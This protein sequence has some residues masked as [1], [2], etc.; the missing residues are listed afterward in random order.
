[1]KAHSS[2][3]IYSIKQT[4]WP[5][6]R[7]SISALSLQQDE[8]ELLLLPVHP[9]L[10]MALSD[11]LVLSPEKS[12]LGISMVIVLR[13]PLWFPASI[14]GKNKISVNCSILEDIENFPVGRIEPN[15]DSGL[16]PGIFSSPVGKETRWNQRL[17][18]SWKILFLKTWGKELEKFLPEIPLQIRE[19]AAVLAGIAIS[20]RDLGKS[21][22]PVLSSPEPLY[23]VPEPCNENLK[24]VAEPPSAFFCGNSPTA[25]SDY[26]QDLAVNKI[27]SWAVD[28][29]FNQLDSQRGDVVPNL[30]RF[31]IKTFRP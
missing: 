6:K 21:R 2:G 20:K 12:D 29:G 13:L 3:I 7:F 30:I 26:D 5:N 4:D 24:L 17:D 9:F 25:P 16:V 14:I 19:D 1:M 31:L 8:N 11:C 15:S 27:E 28:S 22:R 18:S 10:K 23:T